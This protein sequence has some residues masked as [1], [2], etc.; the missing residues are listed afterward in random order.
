MRVENSITY[1]R[2]GEVVKRFGFLHLGWH[3]LAT[4]Y[5]QAG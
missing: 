1:E 4:S 5:G 3:F 2:D